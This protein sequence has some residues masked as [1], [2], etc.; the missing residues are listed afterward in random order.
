MDGHLEHVREKLA[1]N[2]RAQVAAW[3]VNKSAGDNKKK[4]DDLVSVA[5]F[6]TVNGNVN[7]AKRYATDAKTKDVGAAA[8]LQKLAPGI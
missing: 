7:D 8:A 6:C 3:Y 4:A 1:V 2:S 5:V